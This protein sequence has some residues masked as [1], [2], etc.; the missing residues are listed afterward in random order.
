MLLCESIAITSVAG[1]FGITLGWGCLK[2]I[3]LLI[4]DDTIL[5]DKPQINMLVTLFAM[6][7]LIIAGVLA[8]LKPAIYAANLRPI[9]ALKEDN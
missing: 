9:E 3:G 4:D 1:Y 2:L 5:M 6:L 7:I 8:G